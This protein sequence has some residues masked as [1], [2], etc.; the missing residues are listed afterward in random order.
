MAAFGAGQGGHRCW[1][2]GPIPRTRLNRTRVY[3]HIRI[4][5]DTSGAKGQAAG[6]RIPM[7]VQRRVRK[8]RCRE[9]T[10]SA[11]DTPQ[12]PLRL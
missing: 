10:P 12:L 6:L 7:L 5:K 9:L 2:M 3:T 1:H 11:V 8:T 4:S